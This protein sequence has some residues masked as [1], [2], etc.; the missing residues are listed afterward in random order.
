MAT[1][2]A[3]SREAS[4]RCPASDDAI[5]AAMADMVADPGFPC[6]G[7]RSVFRRGAAEIEV[8]PSTDPDDV[9]TLTERLSTFSASHRDPAQL[10]SLLAV[11]RR[12]VPTTEEGFESLLW[13]VLQRLHD[14]DPEPWASDVSGDPS[15]A[16]FAFSVGG[17]PYF[18]VG[19][20][21]AASRMARRAPLPTLVFNLHR[22][23]ER[24]REDDTFARMRTA[25]RRRDLRL[26]GSV[27]PMVDDYGASSAARQYSG[28]AVENDWRA[29]FT[30]S[31]D[32]E[33]GRDR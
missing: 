30:P 1:H 8:L 16:G 20:H 25:I 26:Q 22:Q 31:P 18:V 29:P 33:R 9:A 21:P 17:T 32:T 3:R 27:N 7:A 23:F 11:F 24:L 15:D 12:P 6:L 2:Q 4:S 10:V 14:T 28:R 19:L 13:G 5:A